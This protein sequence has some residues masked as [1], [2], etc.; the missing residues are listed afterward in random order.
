MALDTED[1]NPAFQARLTPFVA[2]L[3]A[4][5]IKASINSGYRTPEYQN[6]MYQNHLAKRAGQPLPFP[7]VEAPDVVAPAWGSFHNYGLAADLTLGNPADYARMASMAPQFGLTGIGASD[8]GHIQMG[9]GRL[10]Q[11]LAANKIDQGW[12]PSGQPAPAQ[13]AV[14][15]SGPSSQPSRPASPTPGPLMFAGVNPDARG[16]RNNNPGNLVANSWT[17]S[18]PGYKGSDGKF[19]IFDTPQHGAAALDQNLTSYGSKGINTPLGIAST[20]AP[21]SDNN[22]PSFYGARIAAALGV[23]PNDKID[24]TDPGVRN[25]IAQVIGSVENGPG[26]SPGFRTA[27]T[28]PTTTGTTLNSPP[29]AAGGPGGPAAPG[30]PGQAQGGLAGSLPGFTA[31]S[32]GAKMTA[33]GLQQLGGGGS[34]GGQGEQPQPMRLAQAP[35]AQPVGGPMMIAPGGQNTFGARTAQNA[36]A[37]QGL[38]QG[39]LTQ[40]SLTAAAN[41]GAMRPPLPSTLQSTIQPMAPGAATGM[42][43][44]PGTTLNSPSQL[45]MALMTGA[46]NPYDLYSGAYS[47]AQGT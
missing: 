13:G 26:N 15:Y 3:G 38:Q 9:G 21:G 40:P 39:F 42:P 18:L 19:A 31:N 46:M 5:G 20:W 17:A 6:Q 16:M 22:N 41:M 36:L 23:G 1:L 35:Q 27:Y 45:Q 2:A 14:A 32:P 4:A 8:P 10:D 29:L 11:V 33:A 24:M 7:N 12:R 28:G 34:Q 47:S 43:G 37:Q 30:Q 25:K 44:L